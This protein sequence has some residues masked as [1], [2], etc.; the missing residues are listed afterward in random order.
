MT[1]LVHAAGSGTGRMLAQIASNRFDAK[2]VGT[3]STRK[4]ANVPL[5][6]NQII[7][8]SGFPVTLVSKLRALTP[9]KRGF[10]VVFDGVG[11]DTY[12]ISLSSCRSRGLV[13]FFGNASGPVPPI[14]PLQ[15]ASRGSL[16][17]TRPTLK[18][19]ISTPEELSVRSKEVF[20]WFD[21]GLLDVT[22]DKEFQ[23]LESINAAIDYVKSGKAS[24]KVV[25]KI[26]TN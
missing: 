4:I 26:G 2:V 18:D 13:V 21:N 23:S 1:V 16:V 5:P 9:D 6:E 7:D 25:V 3:C 10:D 15:L 17:M 8:Y 20:E 22:M 11:K 12:D 24:G 14:D 19:F